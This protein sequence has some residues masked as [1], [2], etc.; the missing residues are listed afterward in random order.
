MK[1]VDLSEFALIDNDRVYPLL[2]Q[3][4]VKNDLVFVD[5]ALMPVIKMPG[6]TFVGAVLAPMVMGVPNSG[7]QARLADGGVNPPK[8]FHEWCNSV[9]IGIWEGEVY[10]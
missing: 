3:L 2:G 8:R 4:D 10:A 5:S 6:S 1:E 7:H 9:V